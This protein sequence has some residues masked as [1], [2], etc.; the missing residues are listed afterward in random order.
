MPGPYHPLVEQWKTIAGTV[1]WSSPLAPEDGAIDFLVPLDIGETTVGGL[2]LRGKA[3]GHLPDRAVT[4]QLEIGQDGM[5]TRVP[6]VRL[7]WRPL[8]PYHQNPDKTRIDGTHIHTFEANWLEGEQ[9]MRRGN[10]PYAKKIAEIHAFK[11]VLDYAKNLFRINGVES[12]PV[13]EWSSTL[14]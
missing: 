2:A 12:V 3:Y 13:P 5:R 10:L 4:F 9:R 1:E 6:L 11:D 8:S 14:F 7:D